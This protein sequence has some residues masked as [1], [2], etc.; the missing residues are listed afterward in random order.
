MNLRFFR[1]AALSGYALAGA[2]AL[3]GSTLSGAALAAPGA[4]G[5]NGEHL[6]APSGARSAGAAQPRLETHSDLFELV[7]EWTNGQLRVYVDRY[8]SNEPVSQATLEV[9]AGAL[10]ATAQYQASE[11]HYLVTA[12]DF[13]AALAQPA[14]HALVFTVVAGE[15]ADLLDGV[16]DTRTAA[17]GVDDHGHGHALEYTAY[18]VGGLLAVGGLWW[19]LGRRRKQGLNRGE[20]A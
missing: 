8:A 12:P 18:G 6:D 1:P 13:L 10:K 20:T 19:A 2:L 11:G 7:A 3:V 14:E 16:L 5:P 4:H 9:Q 15:Q 17:G